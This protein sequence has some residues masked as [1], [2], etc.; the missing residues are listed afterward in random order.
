M[1]LG[2][3]SAII[4]C[5]ALVLGISVFF[6]VS[7]FEVSGAT[8]YTESQIIEASGIKEGSNLVFLNRAAVES[9]ITGEL[10][11]AAMVTVSRRLPNTVV[12]EVRESGTVACVETESGLWLIDNYCRLLEPC[13]N[14]EADNYIKVQGFFA[15]DPKPGQKIS[16]IEEDKPKVAYLEK[17]MTALHAAE[18]LEDVSSIDMS[19]SSNGQFNYLERFN[20]K[21]G[22]DSNLDGKLGLLKSTVEKLEPTDKGNIDLSVSSKAQFSPN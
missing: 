16:S 19:T 14:S 17:L 7:N 15:L 21:L 4:I 11:Y 20:I 18:M 9:R 10:V 12:I 8:H 3:L 2:S 6:R 5:A 1:V 22:R 13:P